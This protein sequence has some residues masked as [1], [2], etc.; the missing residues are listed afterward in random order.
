MT[1][2]MAAPTGPEI[3]NLPVSEA[4][5][6]RLADIVRRRG[7]KRVAYFHCDHFEPWRFARESLPYFTRR[8]SRSRGIST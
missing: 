7:V 8:M 6:S 5:R 4:Y 1:A 2:K 3:G